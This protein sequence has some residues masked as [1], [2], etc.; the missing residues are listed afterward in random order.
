MKREKQK[1]IIS[2]SRRTDLPAFYYDW[3]QDALRAGQVVT[4]NPLYP[5]KQSTVDLNPENVHAL[6]LWSK[7]FKKV[8][9]EPGELSNYN[10]YFQYTITH[11]SSFLEPKVPSYFEQL[12]TLEGLLKT[13]R[14]EQFNIRFDPIIISTKGEIFPTPHKPGL[15]RLLAFEQ[16][17]S[18]LKK[19]GMENCRVTT[20]YLSLYGSV[21]KEL[22][23][24]DLDLIHL[25]EKQQRVFMERMVDI[26][27]RY[28]REIYTCA[29]PIFE[30]IPGVQ[31]GRCIDGDLLNHLFPT[32]CTRAK[33]QGQ[34]K[35]CGCAKSKD[36]GGYLPCLHQCRYCYA[37]PAI[38]AESEN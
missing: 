27:S 28:D 5:E 33:D 37:N 10:L 13:Y 21:Q 16:L 30:G 12:K 11:Y 25:N 2:A 26:A 20:S 14:P 36:I 24:I 7:N 15:A 23:K 35:A 34:R 9:E 18:D 29:N 32:S 8:L 19:L 1:S 31:K 17:C 38:K 22:E 3:L 4:P 6:V